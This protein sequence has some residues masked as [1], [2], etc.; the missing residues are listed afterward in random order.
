[1]GRFIDY[2][3]CTHSLCYDNYSLGILSNTTSNSIWILLKKMGDGLVK[4]FFHWLFLW[5]FGSLHEKGNIYFPSLTNKF[6][7][8]FVTNGGLFFAQD[9]FN[10]IV[11]VFYALISFL[12][13]GNCISAMISL[14]YFPFPPAS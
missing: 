3:K 11:L 8:F 10:Q 6:N 13:D 1:M 7:E 2:K 4:E 14:F 9:T 5:L 12:F